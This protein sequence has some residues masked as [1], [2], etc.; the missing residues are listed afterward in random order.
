MKISN[1]NLPSSALICSITGASTLGGWPPAC[2]SASTSDVNSWPIGTPAKR[3]PMS[4][5]ARLTLNEGARTPATSRSTSDTLSDS[6][7]MSWSSERISPAA[8]EPSSVA[9]SSTGCVT[10]V[11]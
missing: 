6:E 4:A 11:R 10:R 2:S 9:T 3:M 1:S 8:S 5:P 7:A